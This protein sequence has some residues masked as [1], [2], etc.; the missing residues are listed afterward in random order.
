MVL[1]FRP[2]GSCT[3]QT[4]RSGSRTI[5]EMAGK[6]LHN[7]AKKVNYADGSVNYGDY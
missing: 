3:R 5:A 2:L 1:C 7:K 4:G 6:T